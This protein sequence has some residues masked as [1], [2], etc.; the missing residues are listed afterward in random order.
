M[1]RIVD[2][3]LLGVAVVQVAFIDLPQDFDSLE[4]AVLAGTLLPNV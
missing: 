4:K 3:F 2:N 1:L